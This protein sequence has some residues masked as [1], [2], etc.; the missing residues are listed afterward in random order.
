MTKIKQ[1]KIAGVT[2]DRWL[3]TPKK[4]RIKALKKYSNHLIAFLDVLGIKSLIEKYSDGDEHNAIDKIERIRKIVETSTAIVQKDSVRIDFLHISDSVVFVCEPK[5]II[6][7]IELLSTIQMRV[8][9]ECQ[10][11]LRGAITIGDAIAEDYARFIVG[12]AY[13]QA[14]QLQE[15]DAIYP[16]IIVDKS[17]TKKIKEYKLPINN[18]LQ[19]D[20]DKEYFVDYIKVY[21]QKESVSRQRIR[22]RLG[23]EDIYSF[24]KDTFKDNYKNEKHNISQKYGWTIQYFKKLGVWENG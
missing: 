3:E 17:V 6:R 11:L 20:S 4:V 5:T 9:T 19:Q 7:L 2:Y 10:F 24:L 16:R 21:M 12:P 13:I 23:S 22:Y 14:F 8:I 1:R 15:D 18:Y